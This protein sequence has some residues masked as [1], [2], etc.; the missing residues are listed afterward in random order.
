MKKYPIAG[1]LAKNLRVI[2]AEKGNYWDAIRVCSQLVPQG[3]E[4]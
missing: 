2:W 1:R 3:G 4:A